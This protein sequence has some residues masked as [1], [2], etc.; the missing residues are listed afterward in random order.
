MIAATRTIT[1]I[2]CQEAIR[3]SSRIL[4]DK[5]SGPLEIRSFCRADC[6]NM[7]NKKQ[8]TLPTCFK[9]LTFTGNLF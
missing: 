6:S 7:M 5:K 4:N 3:S 8:Y 1:A 2:P 9:K